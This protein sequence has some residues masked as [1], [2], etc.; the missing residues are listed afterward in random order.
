MAQAPTIQNRKAR[1]EFFVL[2]TYEVGIVLTGTEVK[3]IRLGKVVIGDSYVEI[4]SKMELFLINSSI[5]EYLQGNRYN[6]N[7]IRKRKL[8]AHKHEIE[9]MHKAK[10]QK[11]LTI[12]PL[13]LY[14]KKGKVKFEIGV[15]R[16]KNT[17]D[18]RQTLKERD[19]KREAQRAIKQY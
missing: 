15:C 1:H 16:G 17:V 6:H 13:K 5:E 3:S 12:I 8:L 19:Q 14:F 11:G 2:E 7:P 10:E 9:K 18:K 4:S